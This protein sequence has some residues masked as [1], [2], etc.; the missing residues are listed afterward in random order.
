MAE[1]HYNDD[2]PEIL[3][4]V[5]NGGVKNVRESSIDD[6]YKSLVSIVE[7]LNS[8]GLILHHQIDILK[9][10]VADLTEI[11]KQL[12]AD[13]NAL[14]KQLLDTRSMLLQTINSQVQSLLKLH[15]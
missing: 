2:D 5:L 6:T 15:K 3:C 1:L 7:S 4:C 13:N 11:V 8:N 14:K 10:S 9:R 12:S